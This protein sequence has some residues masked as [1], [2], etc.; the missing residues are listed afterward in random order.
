MR[1]CEK[2]RDY[3]YPN[4]PATHGQ[5]C[6]R[7]QV[8]SY[9]SRECQAADWAR[10]KG[11][12]AQ[13]REEANANR[14]PLEHVYGRQAASSDGQPAMPPAQQRQVRRMCGLCRARKPPFKYTE[15][16]R[17]VVCADEGNYVLMSYGRNSCSR[18][19]NRYTN[20]SNHN[21]A[22]HAGRWQDCAACKNGYDEYDWWTFGSNPP[23]LAACCNFPDDVLQGP[24]PSLPLCS[25]CRRPVDTA[26]EAHSFGA[27]G[28]CCMACT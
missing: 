12:C 4:D 23:D 19:H 10:H 9:C 24:R 17:R 14:V 25:G 7:C 6:G 8:V 15:C 1:A 2:C 26:T 18:N 11:E 20:C 21:Q 5:Y 22:G 28:L 13:Q 16:C 27:T 3:L